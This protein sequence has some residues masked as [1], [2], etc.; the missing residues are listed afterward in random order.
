MDLFLG[1]IQICCCIG[2]S[3]VQSELLEDLCPVRM[4]QS[5]SEHPT[6]QLTK[7]VLQLLERAADS[8]DHTSGDRKL[9]RQ[10]S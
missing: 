4:T 6:P 7:E 2:A 1:H 10:P 3:G 8:L 5:G 9:H